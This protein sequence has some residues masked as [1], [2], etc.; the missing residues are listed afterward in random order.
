MY[1]HI[2]VAEIKSFW[3]AFNELASTQSCDCVAVDSLVTRWFAR[4]FRNA[5]GDIFKEIMKIT[6]MKGKQFIF[7]RLHFNV[8]F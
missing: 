3:K 1:V 2:F 7:R 4:V 5:R 6:P 8:N